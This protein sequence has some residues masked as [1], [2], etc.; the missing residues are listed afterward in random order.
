M[1]PMKH[2]I[3]NALNMLLLLGLAT[4][5]WF[6]V[7]Q[8]IMETADVEFKL[9]IRVPAGDKFVVLSHSVGKVRNSD[10]ITVK[11]R[12]SKSQ[13][14]K[15]RSGEIRVV[16]LPVDVDE[17]VFADRDTP[18]H[19]TIKITDENLNLPANVTLEEAVSVDVWVDILE[20]RKCGVVVDVAGIE[21]WIE[22]GKREG[23]S[24]WQVKLR[25]ENVSVT[26]PRSVVSVKKDLKIKTET[27]DVKS[28]PIDEPKYLALIDA[29]KEYKTGRNLP[30]IRPDLKL[31]LS[32][33]TVEATRI[34][35]EE[36]VS[37]VRKNV[38]IG[39][40]GTPEF[41]RE[42]EVEIRPTNIRKLILKV[43]ESRRQAAEQ[44]KLELVLNTAK[45]SPPDYPPGPLDIEILNK[46]EWMDV[47]FGEEEEGQVTITGIKAIKET[48]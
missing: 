43:P 30:D 16:R 9:D 41:F 47:E 46:P 20:T 38:A 48:P 15:L 31:K 45:L 40:L 5:I 23:Q 25:P 39:L 36:I 8:Q 32:P 42:W 35:E 10:R 22:P 11:L 6:Y 34:R 26:G 4:L 14:S 12:G 17:A 18:L 7:Q 21:T 13:L 24:K 19:S 1:S 2:N 44:I 27:V 28:L 3:S 37:I 33:A 29:A